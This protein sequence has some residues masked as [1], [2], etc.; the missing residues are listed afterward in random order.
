LNAFRHFFG[1]KAPAYSYALI[2]MSVF[3]T[4]LHPERS[5]SGTMAILWFRPSRGLVALGGTF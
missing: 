4:I 1:V 5:S 3:L 2:T